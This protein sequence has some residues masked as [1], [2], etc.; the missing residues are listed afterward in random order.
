MALG[1]IIIRQEITRIIT[2]QEAR[3]QPVLTLLLPGVIARAH[4]A[5]ADAQVAEATEAAEV[6]PEAEVEVADNFSRIL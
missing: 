4:Q 1:R 3:N 5:E 2:R 6:V